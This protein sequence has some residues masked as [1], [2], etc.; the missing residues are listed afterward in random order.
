VVQCGAVWRSVVQCGAVWCSVVQ[1]GAVWCSVVQCGAVWCS[2][3]QFQDVAITGF[4][5]VLATLEQDAQWC[6]SV[7]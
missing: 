3:V 7:V 5:L 4:N 2:V 6:C 1:C